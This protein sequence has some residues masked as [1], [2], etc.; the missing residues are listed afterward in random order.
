MIFK[1]LLLLPAGIHE[2]QMYIQ[3]PLQLRPVDTFAHE[4]HIME[5]PK[6]HHWRP[7]ISTSHART[8]FLS[9]D[10]QSALTT[11]DYPFGW[12]GLV[13]LF[14]FHLFYVYFEHILSL[15]ILQRHTPH[16]LV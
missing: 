3:Q 4:L 10:K 9:N 7:F 12:S 15:V 16:V 6:L 2:G 1:R 11:L 14:L 5:Q 8:P 13:D